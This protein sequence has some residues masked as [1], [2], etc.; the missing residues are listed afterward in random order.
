MAARTKFC[1]KDKNRFKKV[2]PFVQRKPRPV[3]QSDNYVEMEANEVT[4][5]NVSEFQYNFINNYAVVPTV[6]ATAKE[7]DPANNDFDASVAL[8]IKD[9]TLSH[10]TITASQKFTGTVFIQV[11]AIY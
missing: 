4:V 5:N 10:V 3:M 11:M 6:T 8:M 2:Y 9:V 1:K 7:L